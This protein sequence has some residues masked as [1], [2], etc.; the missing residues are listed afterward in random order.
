MDKAGTTDAE[1][2]DYV[3]AAARLQDLNLD[4]A[5]LERVTVVF[6][7]NA[8]IARLVLEADIPDA[9]EPAPVFLP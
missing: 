2:Q 9:T 4:P 3:A 1:L 6:V 7:R 5:Q 8:G